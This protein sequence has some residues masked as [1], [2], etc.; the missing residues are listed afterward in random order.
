MEN[1]GLQKYEIAVMLARRFGYT[2]YLEICTRYTG[3]TF[4]KVDK[5]QFRRRARLMYRC[6]AGFSDGEPIDFS[7]EAESG[8]E[9]FD[10]LL[11]SEE[12]F[13]LVFVDPWHTYESSLRDILFGL[14]M[15]KGDGVVLIHDCN[16]PNATCAQLE[17]SPEEWCGLTFAAYLDVVLFT[18]GIHNVTV[19]T[20]YGC[21]IIS[22]DHRLAGLADSQ[23]DAA[24]AGLWQAL[25]LAQKYSFLNENRSRLLRLISP[26]TFRR[27]LIGEPELGQ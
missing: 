16:P 5:H 13:D 21:G 9:L 26:D 7:T 24:L 25:E 12:R 27:R 6:P 4:S 23:P 2:S 18:E 11:K 10:G 8:V 17:V 20:D 14:Q 15:I 22:K 3:H 19:D 1:Q